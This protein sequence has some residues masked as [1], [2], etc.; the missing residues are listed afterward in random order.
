V[1]TQKNILSYFGEGFTVRKT[2]AQKIHSIFFGLLKNLRLGYPF[3][4]KNVRLAKVSLG[5]ERRE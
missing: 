4:I 2:T 3:H 1:N 5:D